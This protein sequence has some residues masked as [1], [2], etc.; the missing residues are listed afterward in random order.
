MTAMV[1]PPDGRPEARH[2]VYFSANSP[3]RP[4][5]L[6][7]DFLKT[8]LSRSSLFLEPDPM[9]ALG[10]AAA[11]LRFEHFLRHPVEFL[12]HDRLAAHSGH[13]GHDQRT[14]LAFVQRPADFGVQRAAAADA[15]EAHV[16][17]DYP[18]DFELAENFVH[19]VGGVRTDG[20]QAHQADFRAA[21]AHV[22]DRVAR[23]YTVR[24]LQEK[25]HVGIVG[26]EF[27]DP[28]IVPASENFREFFVRFFNHRH[29]PFHRAGAL[30][31]QRRSLLRHDLRPVR[32]RVPRIE[33]V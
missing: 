26:H 16:R 33:R 6:V 23:G 3:G 9:G 28:G 21:L 17:L 1:A 29:G 31:L 12:E 13:E 20:A 30:E 14:F 7:Y 24:A 10:N 22:F 32:H 4:I 15:A 25:D 8:L 2:L 11:L 27:F 18:D 19:A 5:K